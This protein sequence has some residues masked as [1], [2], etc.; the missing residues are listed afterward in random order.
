METSLSEN[1]TPELWR[2]FRQLAKA[3]DSPMP[4]SYSV[5]VYPA[6][7]KVE[8]YN[9]LLEFDKWAAV[10]VDSWES[11]P[12][13]LETLLLPTGTYAKFIHH[14]PAHTFFKLMT[15]IMT[16]WLPSSGFRL[17]ERPYFEFMPP[18]YKGPMHP[19][20]EEEVWIP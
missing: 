14:G 10:A 11:V 1:I 19:E 17:A 20:A 3:I 8:V 12:A 15:H 6:G 7:T 9:P 18:E 4:G 13:G 5:Q 2:S 16:E